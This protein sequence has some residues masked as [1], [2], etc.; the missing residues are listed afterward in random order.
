MGGSGI[1][2]RTLVKRYCKILQKHFKQE[3]PFRTHLNDRLPDVNSSSRNQWGRNPIA[4]CSN[5]DIVVKTCES[6]AQA[7]HNEGE[8][9][10]FLQGHED[11][12]DSKEK[13]FPI[14]SRIQYSVDSN[15]VK[16]CD[17]N[18]DQQPRREDRHMIVVQVLVRVR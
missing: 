14:A 17:F 11:V 15:L 7:S 3:K 5:K 8:G 6:G 16:Q 12:R 13:R 18:T 4:C 2:N 9:Y 1:R 10:G